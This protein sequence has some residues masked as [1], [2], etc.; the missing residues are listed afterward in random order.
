[1]LDD[2]T[3]YMRK[4]KDQLGVNWEFLEK[5]DRTKSLRRINFMLE[6]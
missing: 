1:M 3:Q 5:V 4:S 6:K 2:L